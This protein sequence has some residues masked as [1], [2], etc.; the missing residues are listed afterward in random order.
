MRFLDILYVASYFNLFDIFETV[1]ICYKILRDFSTCFNMLIN[2][3]LR[4]SYSIMFTIFTNVYNCQKM[5]QNDSKR[6]WMIYDFSAYS[7]IIM[8]V[9]EYSI[10]AQCCSIL[11]YVSAIL[12]L[13]QDISRY[14]NKV[15][16]FAVF[17]N[18]FKYFQICFNMFKNISIYRVS[19]NILA[20]LMGWADPV[21]AHM[22]R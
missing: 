19:Q 17:S 8:N 16:I 4:F 14:L 12:N 5:F 9:P 21:P 11:W 7:W 15:Q 18:I 10:D 22:P 2:I 6:F 1:S 3:P 13:F 20:W